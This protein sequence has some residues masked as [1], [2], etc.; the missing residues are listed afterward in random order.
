MWEKW[1]FMAAG[2]AATVLLGGPVG[3]IVAEDGGSATI[4]DIVDETAAILERSGHPVRPEAMS[5]VTT[6]LTAAGSPFTTSLY[7]D[8]VA[9]RGTE[10]ETVL[11][12]LLTIA[13][14]HQARSPL[15]RA[16]AVRLRV[17]ATTNA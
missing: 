11:G 3:R 17:H 5:L 6:M 1:F 16:A 10:V 12:D 13:T 15:L 14:R 9:G 4:T 2:G 7:R 8:F